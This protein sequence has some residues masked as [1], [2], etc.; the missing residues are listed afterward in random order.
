LANIKIDKSLNIDG[1][2]IS[3]KFDDK[4]IERQELFWHYP[5]YHGSVWTPGAAIRQGNWKLIEF[6]ESETVEL[7][8]LSEDILDKIIWLNKIQ[9]K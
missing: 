9:R 4:K 3:K 6:Y 1:I 8:N 7:Y 5:Y 2:D